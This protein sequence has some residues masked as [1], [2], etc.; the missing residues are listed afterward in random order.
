MAA[1]A[2]ASAAAEVVALEEAGSPLAEAI[3]VADGA[4]DGVS[5]P[6]RSR[7]VML[8]ARDLISSTG[9]N[10]AYLPFAGGQSELV[11]L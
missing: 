2:A 10:N 9:S 5:P 4:A 11:S 7:A 6:I 1:V 8:L 3:E